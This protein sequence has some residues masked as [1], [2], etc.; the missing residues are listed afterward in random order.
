MIGVHNEANA[1]TYK[2]NKYISRVNRF[3]WKP[4][5][6]TIFEP[7]TWKKYISLSKNENIFKK[8]I[9]VLLTALVCSHTNNFISNLN[10]NW[11]QNIEECFFMIKYVQGRIDV[12]CL[13]NDYLSFWVLKSPNVAGP[14]VYRVR[15]GKKSVKAWNKLRNIIRYKNSEIQKDSKTLSGASLF[16]RLF[17]TFHSFAVTNHIIFIL[18]IC[19]VRKVTSGRMKAVWHYGL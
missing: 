4:F 9:L 3:W 17:T 16:W 19:S 7:M 13:Y 11:R 15:K 8:K 2:I 1:N 6:D 5:R 12:H 14:S 10:K 18:R